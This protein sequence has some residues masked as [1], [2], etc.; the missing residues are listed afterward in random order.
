MCWI[1][2]PHLVHVGGTVIGYY[3]FLEQ[4]PEDLA[5]PIGGLV[6]GELAVSE[7]LRQE[8]GGSFYRISNELREERDKGKESDDVAGWFYFLAIDIDGVTER[9]ESIERDSYRK[10]ERKPP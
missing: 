5:H 8:V 7:E 3:D 1:S 10:D 6:V 4:A 9:L 2:C